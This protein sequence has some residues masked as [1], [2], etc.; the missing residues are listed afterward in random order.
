MFSI[1][2]SFTGCVKS[3]TNYQIVIL[4]GALAK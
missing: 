3:K 4:N 1:A 2:M